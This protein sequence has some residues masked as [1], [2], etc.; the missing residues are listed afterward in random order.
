MK[1]TKSFLFT[2]SL[3]LALA[4]TI[5]CSSSDDEEVGNT[6]ACTIPITEAS[7]GGSVC[8]EKIYLDGF[9][10]KKSNEEKKQCKREVSGKASDNCS[11][12]Y[13]QKCEDESYVEGDGRKYIM[14]LYGDNHK[15]ENCSSALKEYDF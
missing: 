13:T 8:I 11:K 2:A 5:S 4:F 9:S 1:K 12:G 10:S 15:N 3:A 6:V 7:G 14:Y